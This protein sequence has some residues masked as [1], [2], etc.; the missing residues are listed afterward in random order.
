G[1]FAE[2]RRLAPADRDAQM[3]AAAMLRAGQVMDVAE[4]QLVDAV[5]SRPDDLKAR[6]DLADFYLFTA[7]PKR[8]RQTLEA[9]RAPAGT[10]EVG[11]ADGESLV[12]LARARQADGDQAG[13]V[14]AL[15]QA[16]KLNRQNGEAWYRLGRCYLRLGKNDQARDALTHAM[17]GYGNHP[18][19]PY[20]LGM[21]YMQQSRPADM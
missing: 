3:G 19:T 10:H 20:F 17:F 2:A 13:A 16:L 11:G 1:E 4:A 14:D 21:T 9:R 12:M 8:A 5:R 7:A 18:E 15:K 6:R